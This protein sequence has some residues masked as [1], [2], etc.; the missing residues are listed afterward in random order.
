MRLGIR[1]KE[2]LAVTLLALLIVATTTVIHLSQL[3]R[4]VVAEAL[5]QAQLISRQI[6]AQTSQALARNPRVQP[7]EALKGDREL[8]GLLDASVGYS[9]DL[10]YALIADR[11]GPPRPPH[12]ACQ[13]RSAGSSA[14]G[15]DG[16]DRPRSD[17]PLPRPLP[18]RA[19][20]RDHTAPPA[21][22]R[23]LREHPVGRLHD[24][25]QA[26]VDGRRQEEPDRRRHRPARGLARGPGTGA[27]DPPAHPRP[28]RR[29][30][31][32]APRRVRGGCRAS[33][34]ATSSRSCRRSS[35][36][37]AR[38]CRPIGSRRSVSGFPSST[39]SIS[40]R[41]WSSSSARSIGSCSSTRRRR[42]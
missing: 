16:A 5:H 40:S 7:L 1:I 17:Q 24:T 38:S 27:P 2:A 35:S 10:V 9:P 42:A 6:Y 11:T 18:E 34:A 32:H 14:T 13:G 26:R 29:G 31:P 36:G 22:W 39:S 3:S 30:G 12:G 23:A 37:S 28:R 19:C 25:G 15:A 41:M 4:V 8:R 20:L 33:G 21:E